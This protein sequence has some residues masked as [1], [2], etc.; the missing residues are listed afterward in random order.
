MSRQILK[1][2][3]TCQGFTLLEATIAM[4][5]LA[6][7]AS[8]V[9]LSFTAAASVQAEAHRRILASRLA[10]D[11]V[12]IIAAEDFNQIASSFPV[13]SSQSAE[14]MG[15]TGRMYTDYTCTIIANRSVE[16]NDGGRM[17]S[18]IEVTV[19]AYYK[20]IEIT[21]ITTLIGNRNRN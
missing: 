10:A 20:N 13:G 11:M 16:V 18:L 9:F 5:I 1:K 4:V 19:A 2:T 21:Q 17:V 14:E 15:N 3:S 12:E 6:V 8:G 7:A